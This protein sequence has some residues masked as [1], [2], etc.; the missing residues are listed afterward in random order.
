MVKRNDKQNKIWNK[1]FDNL[2]VNICFTSFYRNVILSTF[3]LDNYIIFNIYKFWI[4][5]TRSEKQTNVGDT[6]GKRN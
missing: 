3:Y 4:N 1:E 2:Y 5:I 6:N